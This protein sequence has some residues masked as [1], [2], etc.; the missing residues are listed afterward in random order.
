MTT[1]VRVNLLSTL[2]FA[3][4]VAGGCSSDPETAKRAFVKSG[5]QYV[6]DKKYSEAIIQY[7][8]AIQKDPKFGEAR[9]KLADAY[10]QTGDLQNAGRE[11]LRAADLLALMDA[12][13]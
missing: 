4:L 1:T 7:R 2:L 13:D 3:T 12:L 6:A 10:V 8:N 11:Y 5:D 9:Q